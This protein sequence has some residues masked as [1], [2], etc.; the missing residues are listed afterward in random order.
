M[1]RKPARRRVKEARMPIVAELIRRGHNYREIQKEVKVRMNLSTYS[2]DTVHHDVKSTLAEWRMQR[3]QDIDGYIQLELER[4]HEQMREAWAAWEK[5]KLD[6]KSK[7]KTT[8]IVPK[9]THKEGEKEG[10]MKIAGVDNTEKDEVG[11]GD[12][13]F[14]AELRMLA[15]QRAKLLGLFTPTKTELTG[16]NGTGLFEQL[17]DEELEKKVQ[18]YLKILTVNA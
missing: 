11:F 2:L 7:V 5:S 1:P 3:D 12:P 18:Q 17:S 16:K 14:L 4:N 9:G 13:A 8:R 10:S 15:D 6:Y